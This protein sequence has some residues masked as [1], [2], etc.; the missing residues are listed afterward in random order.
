[1][2]LSHPVT[3]LSLL[4]FSASG[5]YNLSIASAT[6]VLGPWEEEYDIDVL[7]RAE[8]FRVSYSLQFTSFCINLHLL[9]EKASLV[10]GETLL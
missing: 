1:M 3:T 4:S 9:K 7:F 2:T 6:V 5:A 10:K 8:H